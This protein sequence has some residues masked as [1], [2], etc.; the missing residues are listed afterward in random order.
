MNTYPNG[1]DT[2][3][4]KAVWNELFENVHLH[5]AQV[6]QAVMLVT[7]ELVAR[8]CV[9]DITGNGDVQVAYSP[10]GAKLEQLPQVATLKQASAEIRALSKALGVDKQLATVANEGK[11]VIQLVKADRDRKARRATG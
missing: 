5:A 10:D 2:E 1:I 8:Q 9:S 11:S 7:W 4:A 3:D 6:P